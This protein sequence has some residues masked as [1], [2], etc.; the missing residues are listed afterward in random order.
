MSRPIRFGSPV[1]RKPKGNLAIPEDKLVAAINDA[2]KSLWLKPL[3]FFAAELSIALWAV[4][5]KDESFLSPAKLVFTLPIVNVP[6]PAELFFLAPFFLIALHVAVLLHE[7]YFLEKLAA[8]QW[9]KG[10]VRRVLLLPSIA[11]SGH[12]PDEY[13]RIIGWLGFVWFWSLYVVLPFCVLVILQMSLLRM[14]SDSIENTISACLL[15]TFLA[16]SYFVVIMQQMK[17]RN[18][19]LWGPPVRRVPAWAGALVTAVLVVLFG[20]SY[21]G[22]LRHPTSCPKEENEGRFLGIFPIHRYLTLAYIPEELRSIDGKFYSFRG[23]KLKCATFRVPDLA[24]ADFRGANL[25]GAVF[26]G[27]D[28]RDADFSSFGSSRTILR[29]AKFLQSDLARAKFNNSLLVDVDFREVNLLEADFPGANLTK[30]KMNRAN[31]V[32]ADLTDAQ[33][34]SADFSEALLAL[35]SFDDSSF[36]L[37]KFD[38]AWLDRA[39]FSRGAAF[40]ASFRGALARK[41]IGIPL[42]GMDLQGASVGG[43]DNCSDPVGIPGHVN[44]R[45][46]SFVPVG[47]WQSV[48]KEIRTGRRGKAR[49]QFPA[50][51]WEQVEA[52]LNK[53]VVAQGT[54][55]FSDAASIKEAQTKGWVEYLREH[56]ILLGAPQDGTPPEGWP[57]QSPVTE[58][59]YLKALVHELVD[60]RAC[61]DEATLRKDGLRESTLL[62]LLKERTKEH[63]RF[64]DLLRQRLAN[65]PCGLPSAAS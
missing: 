26:D 61:D 34:R 41:A 33:L 1:K 58:E 25:T 15:V 45:N 55:C 18:H 2:A 49:H 4:A 63:D 14:G 43:A 23:L 52:L 56:N 46:L 50:P 16:S 17:R 38:D 11:I 31:L 12:F 10:E 29:E 42:D 62:Y 28:L 32:G 8:L 60:R 54:T 59:E 47:D 51:V 24:R 40:G 13:P 48:L 30:A 35:A 64:A 9:K 37:A 65:S 22:A 27:V 5:L 39:S 7:Y 20:F 53:P 57:R 3:T 6:V 21:L 36:E 44:L 19:S